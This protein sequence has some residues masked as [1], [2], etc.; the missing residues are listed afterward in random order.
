MLAWSRGVVRRVNG[1]TPGLKALSLLELLF[2]GLK[3]DA[4]T[5]FAGL[6]PRELGSAREFGARLANLA[7]F[8]NLT[9]S[10]IWLRS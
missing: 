6:K 7:L 4:S 1:P 3:A 5:V 9:R 10:R 8:Q 2:V